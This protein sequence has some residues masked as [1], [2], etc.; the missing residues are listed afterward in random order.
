[1][2]LPALG[3]QYLDGSPRSQWTRF[4]FRGRAAG[5]GL[6]PLSCVLRRLRGDPRRWFGIWRSDLTLALYRRGE[7]TSPLRAGAVILAT[8]AREQMVPFP[9]WMLAGRDDG[10]RGTVAGEA[11]RRHPWA[12][13]LACRFGAAS[14]SGGCPAGRARRR[15]C[16]YSGSDPPAGM[17]AARPG[18]VGQL[19]SPDRR[20]PLRQCAP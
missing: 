1:M 8:G 16:G 2:S 6:D 19:G 7:V 12:P 20:P 17:A 3:G 15:S 11:P 4:G 5:P 13:G 9:G 18:G 10:G 14:A